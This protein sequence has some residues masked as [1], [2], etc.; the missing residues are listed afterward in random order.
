M[1]IRAIKPEDIPGVTGL[2]PDRIFAT[3]AHG[4][5]QKIGFRTRIGR[6]GRPVGSRKNKEQADA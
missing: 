4:K 5:L 6:L 2:E 1:W 3:D